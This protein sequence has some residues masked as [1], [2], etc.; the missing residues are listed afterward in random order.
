MQ[1]IDDFL[2]QKQ[3]TKTVSAMFKA[4]VSKQEPGFGLMLDTEKLEQ[5]W[6]A[7]VGGT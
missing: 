4:Y 2:T 1:H 6:A 5:L 3:I 7:F